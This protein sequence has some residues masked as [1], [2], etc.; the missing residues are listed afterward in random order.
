MSMPPAEERA[1]LLDLLA[2]SG[3]PHDALARDPA[4]ASRLIVATRRRGY[5]LRQGG[6]IWPHTSAVALPI[7]V[8]KRVLGCIN[9]VWMA[10]V[11]D[12]KQGVN[13]CLG[14]LR[15]AQALIEQQLTGQKTG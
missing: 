8:G 11:L 6:P 10:R 14:P 2:R 3:D 12:Y 4:Q 13:R 15:E 9:T 1:T 5:G 7:R